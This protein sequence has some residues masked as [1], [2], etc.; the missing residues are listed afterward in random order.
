MMQR[1]P[2]EFH[3]VEGVASVKVKINQHIFPAF[4]GPPMFIFVVKNGH[5]WLFEQSFGSIDGR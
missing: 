2:I 4:T 3:L 1:F 5:W